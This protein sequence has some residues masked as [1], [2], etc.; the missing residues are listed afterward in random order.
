[1]LPYAGLFVPVCVQ[2]DPPLDAKGKPAYEVVKEE[3]VNIFS[4]DEF[5]APGETPLNP[6][7]PNRTPP[8]SV[9]PAIPPFPCAGPRHTVNVVN[10]WSLANFDPTSV[11]KTGTALALISEARTRFE[12]SLDPNHTALSTNN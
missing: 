10:D 5:V 3:D 2:V 4:G 12:K 11:R 9:T 1:M 6:P 8:T 7:L